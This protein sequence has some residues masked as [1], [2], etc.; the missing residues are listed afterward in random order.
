MLQS[1][2]S[3][4][5]K[6]DLVT[7]QNSPQSSCWEGYHID[8]KLILCDLSR[9]S[10]NKEK[11]ELRWEWGTRLALVLNKLCSR[12]R[13]RNPEIMCLVWKTFEC[14]AVTNSATVSL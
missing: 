6:H 4:R 13:G 11:S 5:V 7:K 9:A 2:G 12:G 1:L 3:Q 8:D 14:W 10:A